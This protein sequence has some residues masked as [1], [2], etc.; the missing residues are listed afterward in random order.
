MSVQISIEYQAEGKQE[1]KKH[2]EGSADGISK[3]QSLIS[4]QDGIKKQ[5]SLHR[6]SRLA[7]LLIRVSVACG[8]SDQ[9]ADG[10]ADK[11][12]LISSAFASAQ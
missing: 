9:Q 4:N 3:Q 8:K 6:Q 1:E 11:A 2:C 12:K 7:D 5:I 10:K